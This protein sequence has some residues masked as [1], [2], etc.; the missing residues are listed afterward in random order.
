VLRSVSDEIFE[1]LQLLLP[2]LFLLTEF[3]LIWKEGGLEPRIC[4]LQICLAIAEQI[5][6]I[7]LAFHL[8]VFLDLKL[9]QLLQIW[10]LLLQLAHL[11]TDR[12]YLAIKLSFALILDAR[13]LFGVILVIFDSLELRF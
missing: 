7:L 13:L 12:F 10:N 9:V 4:F 6:Q 8:S 5:K 3:L 11:G 2:H 1:I